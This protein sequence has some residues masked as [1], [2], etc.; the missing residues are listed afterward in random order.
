MHKLLCWVLLSLISIP[1]FSQSKTVSCDTL[2]WFDVSRNRKIP[3]AIFKP[4]TFSK[5]KKYPVVIFNHGYGQNDGTAYLHYTYLTNFLAENGFFVLSIQHELTTDSLIPTSGIP[6]IV[7]RPFWERG[8]V[9]IH[10]AIDQLKLQYPRL[11]FKNLSL[12]GHSNGGDI[13]ALFGQKYPNLVHKLITLDNRRMSLPRT[14]LPKIYTLRSSDQPAD[15]GV[16]P[17]EFEQKKWS[18]QI[19]MLPNTPHNNMD[20]HADERQGKEIQTYVLHFLQSDD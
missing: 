4:K 3:I 20:N 9:N 17:N 12:I 2:T 15:E 16:L 8:V 14:K 7:R 19:I 5:T 18:I 6:Q 1:L 11:D 10:F 13:T